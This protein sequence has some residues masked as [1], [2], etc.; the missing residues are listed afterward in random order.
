MPKILVQRSSTYLARRR[1]T[2]KDAKKALAALAR[3]GLPLAEFAIRKG[4]VAHRLI[5]WQQRLGVE[6]PTAPD[7]PHVPDVS[8]VLD[9]ITFEEVV[10]PELSRRAAVDRHTP[11]DVRRDPFELVLPTGLIVRVAESFNADAL[12]RLLTAISEVGRC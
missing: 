11:P 3:S 5:R 4:L 1:W 6:L 7:I 8:D 2:P 12:V 10:P 9:A